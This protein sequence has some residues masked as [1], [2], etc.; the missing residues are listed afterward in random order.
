MAVL[1]AA[2]VVAAALLWKVPAVAPI[3]QLP[4]GR[5]GVNDEMT[6]VWILAREERLHAR[7]RQR[8]RGGRAEIVQF[9]RDS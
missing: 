2:R 7:L 8:C 3:Q 1:H 4:S 9:A 6:G 5:I